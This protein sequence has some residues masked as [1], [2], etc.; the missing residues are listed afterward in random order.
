MDVLLA[1]LRPPDRVPVAEIV[2]LRVVA[3]NGA[4]R[5]HAV[6]KLVGH[7][8]QRAHRHFEREQ[9]AEG[10]GE[11]DG[12]LGSFDLHPPGRQRLALRRPANRRGDAVAQRLDE[13]AAGRRLT[14]IEQ[15]E[16]AVR[17][18][19]PAISGQD[20]ALDVGELD[21]D[22]AVGLAHDR[23]TPGVG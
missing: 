19:K 22:R 7:A 2:L 9:A 20:V 14:H 13:G 6:D 4:A 21:I 1:A 11:I 10:E 3:E 12:H 8:A 16:A 15:A 18:A 23:S 5:G 17:E